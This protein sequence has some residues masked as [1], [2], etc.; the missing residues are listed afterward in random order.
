MKKTG[1]T[2]FLILSLSYLFAQQSTTGKH[3]PKGVSKG[4]LLKST[5]NQTL[6]NNVP[7]YIWRHGC[8]PTALGMVIGY[9]DIIGYSD[10]IT[11][12]AAIQSSSVNNAI[13]TSEHYNDYSEPIDYYPDLFQDKSEL[14]GAHT[15]DCIADFMQTSWSSKSNRYGWSWS[16]MIDDAFVNYIQ[17]ENTDYSVQTGYERYSSGSWDVYV[18]EINNNRPV[19]L[20][21]DSDGDGST[22]H[23]VTGIGYDD[24]NSTYA[25]YDT[26]DNDVH[27]YQ[28]RELSDSYSWGIYG[29]NIL[30]IYFAVS[31]SVNPSNSGTIS[32][33]GN[34]DYGQTA[35]LTATPQTGYN[36]V[37]WTENGTQVSTNTNYSFTVTE[38]KTLVANF[39]I[40]TGINEIVDNLT[41]NIYPNPATDI[42]NIEFSSLISDKNKLNIIL[43]DLLGK[44]NYVNNFSTLKNIITIDMTGKKT[45]IYYIQVVSDDKKAETKKIIIIR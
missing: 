10:L 11:G 22:D 23:F 16:N 3:R 13:A 18:N 34:Y 5:N 8:G 25:I 40:S 36:F 6:I 24:A 31:A 20:L 33:A 9:Y 41:F 12:D 28:W 39:E 19:V 35:N 27:W 26:W 21:V 32:G 45:G 44:V 4:I 7:S 1:F 38:N 2:I 43:I 15:S 17:Q 42:I 30:K 37:N 29:F 14:G